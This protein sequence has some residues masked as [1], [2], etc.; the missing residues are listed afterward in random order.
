MSFC[1]H[2]GCPVDNNETLCPA[3]QARF[4]RQAGDSF[5]DSAVDAFVNTAD[6]TNDY[7][8]Q[9]IREN[10]V[11]AIICY[12]FILFL[13]PLFVCTNSRFATYHAKQAA[14]FWIV[15]T[16]VDLL[17]SIISALCNDI[18]GLGIVFWVISSVL[19]A[20]TVG[21]MVL[22]IV[23]AATGKAKALPIVGGI[24]FIS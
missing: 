16:A 21:L 15:A 11:M 4:D 9:D 18:D 5:F 8:F 14:N 12:I 24:R 23:Y 6:S 19:Y 7:S 2:C 10:K 1:N 13:I 17:F 3:C 20:A 22:G